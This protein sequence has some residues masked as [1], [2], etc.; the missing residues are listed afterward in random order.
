MDYGG[1]PMIET[2]CVQLQ[3]A[4]PLIAAD[5][6]HLH[7]LMLRLPPIQAYLFYN[8]NLWLSVAIKL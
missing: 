3:T 5:E 8:S 7:A 1:T 4:R 6:Y 2:I